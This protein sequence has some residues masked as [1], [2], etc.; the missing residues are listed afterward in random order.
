MQMF[1]LILVLMT[2]ALIYEMYTSQ[3]KF[4]WAALGLGL[5]SLVGVVIGRVFRI[6]WHPEQGQVVG[7]LDLI[8]IVVLILYITFSLLRHWIFAHWF[9]GAILTAFTVS[10]VE[11]AMLGRILRMR[12]DIKNVLIEEG[13]IY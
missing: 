11:G 13:M 5:G 2:G 1:G 4:L 9:K 10:F 7:N 12:H 6:Q 3:I 8:G